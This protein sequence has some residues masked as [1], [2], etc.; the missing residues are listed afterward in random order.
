MLKPNVDW[1]VMG[2]G[3]SVGSELQSSR[4]C[5][6]SDTAGTRHSNNTIWPSPSSILWSAFLGGWL[7]FFL[8][9]V[10]PL[11][12]Q[13]GLWEPLI[14]IFIAEHPLQKR[15]HLLPSNSH[16]SLNWLN[17]LNHL[18]LNQSLW[19]RRWEHTDWLGLNCVPTSLIPLDRVGSIKTTLIWTK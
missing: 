6:A 17:G 18:C 9:Q 8:C 14:R 5:L 13:D 3:T 2:G 19:T 4:V 11:L 1:L 10:L 16:K 7:V 15:E 12:R